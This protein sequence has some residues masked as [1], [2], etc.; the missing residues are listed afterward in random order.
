MKNSYQPL[1]EQL[2]AGRT[3]VLLRVSDPSDGLVLGVRLPYNLQAADYPPGRGY[4]VTTAGSRLV[5]LAIGDGAEH[6]PTAIAGWVARII[7]RT[8]RAGQRAPSRAGSSV[9]R[10]T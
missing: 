2:R 5:Q 8:T 6:E 9:A 1:V 3:G 4:L 10:R 7:E